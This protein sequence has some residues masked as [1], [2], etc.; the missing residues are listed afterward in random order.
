MSARTTRTLNPLPFQD[1]EPHRFE[2]L[3]RQLAY[4]L[5]PWISLEAV[6]RGGSDDGID[7]RG[8]ELTGT[9]EV[10]LAEEPTEGEEADLP[11]AG[12]NRLWIIQCKREKSMGPSAV[13]KVI[14]ESLRSLSEPPYGF[15]LAVAA[16]VSKA[17]RD[18][19]RSEMATRGIER[20][21]IWAKGELEDQLFQPDND[22]LLFAYFNI[23]LHARQR[24]AT[25]QI[26]SEI[27]IKRQ[28]Q[29]VIDDEK[30]HWK[31]V[32]LRDPTDTRYPKEPG[33]GEPPK[34]WRLCQ[35]HSVL[36]PGYLTV[37]AHKRLAAIG[38]DGSSWD[39]LD[40][41]DDLISTYENELRNREAWPLAEAHERDRDCDPAEAF[42]RDYIE[43]ENRVYFCDFRLIDLR[44][45]MAIDWIGDGFY[46]LPQ[47][48]VAPTP[49]GDLFSAGKGAWLEPM[50]SHVGAIAC[51]PQ[52]RI[53]IFPKTIPSPGDLPPPGFDESLQDAVALMP[54]AADRLRALLTTQ[55]DQTGDRRPRPSS[56]DRSRQRKNTFDAWKVAVGLPAFSAF[57]QALRAAGHDARVVGRGGD[58]TSHRGDMALTLR[59]K[60]R[61]TSAYN[62]LYWVSGYVRVRLSDRLEWTLDASTRHGPPSTSRTAA[63]AIPDTGPNRETLDILVTSVLENLLVG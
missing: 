12:E 50:N 19:F 4:G 37:M 53:A 32:L 17:T 41:T 9:L 26:R 42:W 2:D 34:R 21:F 56:L 27:V 29:K 46:P 40:D 33:S 58:A 48:M 35:I 10:A 18:V 62:P 57:V 24:S 3:V 7:I 25:S 1:L 6:G 8:I 30:N 49:D 38:A 63:T 20:F 47:V 14:A 54:E 11:N 59:I 16:D 43:D 45:V 61:R 55:Q 51:D 15:I 31:V 23:S 60:A 39:M 28:L 44:R 52:K 22:R 5:R 13:R 36:Q